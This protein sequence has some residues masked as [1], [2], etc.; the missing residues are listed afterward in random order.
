MCQA[1]A[2]DIGSC[3]QKK[4]LIVLLQQNQTQ[5]SFTITMRK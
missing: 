1:R 2:L 3:A 5:A 4:D